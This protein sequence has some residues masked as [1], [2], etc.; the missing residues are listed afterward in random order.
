MNYID[1]I[2]QKVEAKTKQ[3]IAAMKSEMQ[4]LGIKH[5]KGPGLEKSLR[6]KISFDKFTGLASRIRF[7]FNLEGVFVHK[8]VG[9]GGTTNRVVKEWFNPIIEKFA[10][11]LANEV[12]GGIVEIAYKRLKIH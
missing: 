3:C 12:L 4:R 7:I 5:I 9:R 8:G 10:D 6:F 1:D 2:N 11:E